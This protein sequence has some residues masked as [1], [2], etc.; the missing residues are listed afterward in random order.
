M[1]EIH[2]ETKTN[3]MSIE[4]FDDMSLEIELIMI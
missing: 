2:F 1:I 3:D 4:R